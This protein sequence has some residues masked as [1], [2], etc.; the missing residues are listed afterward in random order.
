M[1]VKGIDAT[2]GSPA[3]RCRPAKPIN[4]CPDSVAGNLRRVSK[5]QKG[6]C[7][8]GR[9][10]EVLA[11]SAKDFLTN[12]HTKT[13]TQS[14]LPKRNGWRTN[15]SEQYRGNKEAL[16]YLVLAHRGEQNFPKTANH[17]GDKVNG[18]K[19]RHAVDE[20]I[21][22]S[23]TRTCHC[24]GLNKRCTQAPVANECI[25]SYR[26]ITVGLEADIP[27]TEKHSGECTQPNG[28]HNTLQI[29][30][31]AHMRGRGCYGARSVENSIDSFVKCIPALVLTAFFKMMLDSIEKL[32]DSCHI[33]LRPRFGSDSHG[34]SD[35]IHIYPGTRRC[36]KPDL[37]RPAPEHQASVP[38]RYHQQSA[39]EAAVWAGY[40]VA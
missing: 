32:P 30:A 33:S 24:E 36:T 5:V 11:G 2:T 20:V 3:Q 26:Q 38:F 23:G 15:Q 10:Q 1:L 31:I 37:L 6:S 35:H 18:H 40:P 27:H 29:D 4:C 14:H 7:G 28:N 9:V 12:Y 25:G 13:D 22:D 34:E 39:S 8:Q 16:V 19:I 17:K 21:P